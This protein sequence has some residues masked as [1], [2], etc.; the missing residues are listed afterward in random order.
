MSESHI[1]PHFNHI[2][3]TNA[4]VLFVFL[5]AIYDTNDNASGIT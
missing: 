5:S 3:L 2:D 4:I 1:A